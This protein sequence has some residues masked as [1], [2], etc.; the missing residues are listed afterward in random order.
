MRDSANQLGSGLSA[1]GEAGAFSVGRLRGGVLPDMTR[2]SS[3]LQDPGFPGTQ[4]QRVGAW[5]RVVGVGRD[6]LIWWLARK[7]A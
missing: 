4:P 6:M 5:W 7:P 2:S 1:R 3:S